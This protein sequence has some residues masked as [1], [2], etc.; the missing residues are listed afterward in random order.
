[1]CAWVG[2][3]AS[4]SVPAACRE[5]TVQAAATLGTQGWGPA[6]LVSSAS[7]LAQTVLRALLWTRFRSFLLLGFSLVTVTWLTRE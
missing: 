6:G 1:M 2:G 3:P 7:A 5:A 4:I